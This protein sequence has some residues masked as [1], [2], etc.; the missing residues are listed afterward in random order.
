MGGQQGREG[1]RSFRKIL[2]VDDDPALRHS[3]AEQLEQ[4]GEFSA[5]ECD[6][7]V[8]AL[9]TAGRER[10]DAILLDI[11]LPDMDGRELC[12]RMRSGGGSAP[13]VILTPGGS[14][15]GTGGRPRGRA[16]EYL[17]KP[18]PAPAPP[19]RVGAH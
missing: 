7:A 12:R 11:G 17:K 19:A 8:E 13:I 9:A 16:Q 2:I 18:V 1:M 10:F 4:H 14:E 3:L 5:V 6:T 15:G